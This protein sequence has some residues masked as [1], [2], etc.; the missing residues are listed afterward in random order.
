MTSIMFKIAALLW[1]F[2][3]FVHVMAGVVIIPGDVTSGIQGI[4]AAVEPSLLEMDYHPAVGA[5]LNQHAWNLAWAGAVT[6]IAAFYVWHGNR[7]AI[8]LAALVAGL[9]D[10]GYFAFIDLGGYGNFFPGRSMTYVCAAAIILSF[11]AHFQKQ[12]AQA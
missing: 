5:I 1:I 8:Y 7:L 2:W 6:T 11:Y 9:T 4:A 3:G 10:I 12:K